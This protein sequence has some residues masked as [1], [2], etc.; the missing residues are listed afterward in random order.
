MD[1]LG[2]NR[3]NWVETVRGFGRLFK[4]AAG[5]PRSLLDAEAVV[6][7][8]G[9]GSNRL[10]VGHWLDAERQVDIS[11]KLSS[12]GVATLARSTRCQ[13]RLDIDRRAVRLLTS[14]DHEQKPPSSRFG[15]PRAGLE[16]PEI[17]CAAFD[18]S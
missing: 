17:G 18:C 12:S 5:R 8:Q 14:R 11:I 6:P 2:I 16:T 9:G 7:G 4:Q 10:C 15:R 1:R 13:Y 3:S